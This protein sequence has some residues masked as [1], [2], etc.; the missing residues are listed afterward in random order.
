MSVPAEALQ[1]GLCHDLPPEV[2][3]KYFQAQRFRQTFEYQTAISICNQC[4]IQED[5]LVDAIERPQIYRQRGI[6]GGESAEAI[7]VLEYQHRQEGTPV[8]QLARTAI[9]H[10]M[11]LQGRWGSRGLRAGRFVTGGLLYPELGG[12]A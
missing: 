10:Q 5:C 11:P 2:A 8:R 12:E 1:G 6:R 7:R 9:G 4:P 3:D